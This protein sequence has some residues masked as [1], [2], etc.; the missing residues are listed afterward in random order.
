MLSIEEAEAVHNPQDASADIFDDR[1]RKL[2]AC[3][4]R[5]ERPRHSGH[6]Q[7]VVQGK[8]L[9]DHAAGKFEEGRRDENFII[10]AHEFDLGEVARYKRA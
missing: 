8:V 7:L 1:S 2:Q 4:R 5:D 10:T 9:P 3:T 6:P